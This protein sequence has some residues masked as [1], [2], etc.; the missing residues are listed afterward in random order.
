MTSLLRGNWTY[1]PSIA[2]NT[3]YLHR[4]EFRAEFSVVLDLALQLEILQAGGTMLVDDETVFL[5]RRH[6]SSV[7]SWTAVDGT[8]FAQES[9]LFVE[10][11]RT[12]RSMGWTRAARAAKR[13]LTSRLNALTQLPRAMRSADPQDRKLLIAHVVSRR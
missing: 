7:S 9:A 12:L 10:T 4:F 6:A 13:H 11:E 5:Y 3:E 8:R 1:F 2:W